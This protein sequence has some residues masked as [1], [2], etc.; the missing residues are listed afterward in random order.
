[1]RLRRDRKQQR[2]REAVERQEAYNLLSN[3]EKIGKLK[4]ARGTS[5]RQQAKLLGDLLK[6]ALPVHLT[7]NQIELIVKNAEKIVDKFE[8]S[9]AQKKRRKRTK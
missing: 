5:A 6:E 8:E 1:M 2:Q 3:K 4:A 9:K 7:D